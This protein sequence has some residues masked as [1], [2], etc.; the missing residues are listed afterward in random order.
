MVSRLH[1]VLCRFTIRTSEVSF[2]FALLT[3]ALNSS[4]VSGEEP[5][6]SP[7]EPNAPS[8]F[9]VSAL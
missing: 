7:S 3:A 4:A 8:V 2:F 6:L 1:T 5:V 9:S